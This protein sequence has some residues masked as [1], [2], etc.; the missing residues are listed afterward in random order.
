[1]LFVEISFFCPLFLLISFKVDQASTASG[2]AGYRKYWDLILSFLELCA[3]AL[4]SLSS[5]TW[6][7]SG[8]LRLTKGEIEREA[9][10]FCSMENKKKKQGQNEVYNQSFM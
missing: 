10:G 4:S 8:F 6:T 7:K 2:K 1:M 9:E 3:E 5:L